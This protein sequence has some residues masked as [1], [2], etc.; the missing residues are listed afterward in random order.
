MRLNRHFSTIDAHA[1]GEPLR[2][3]TGGLPPLPGATIL[4]RRRYMREHLD[5]VR[6][7]LMYEPRGHHG[8]YG[9]VLMPPASP[10]GDLGVLFMH[11]EGYSTMCGH[12]IIA[13]TTAVLETGLL[14]KEGPEPTVRYDTPAGRV[15]ARAVME[16]ERVAAVAF[17]N[18]PSFVWK[19]GLRVPVDG[20]GEVTADIVFGGAFYAFVR[21]E[22]LGLRVRP[23]QVPQ[24]QRA[25][26]AIKAQIEATEDVHH[27]EEPELRDIYGVIFYDRPD[28][29]GADWRNV[30][31]FADQQIDR[32]PC[33]TG[34]SAR[35]AHLHFLGELDP[36]D[37]FIHESIVGSRFVG[38]ILGLTQV[39]PYQAILPE[40]QGS[41]A[42]TGFHQFVVDP[43]DPL[44]R[45]FLL[46]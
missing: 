12:G 23:E 34:T 5:D 30:C 2:I 10:D 19:A 8:M 15:V 31:V 6:Q 35:L 29:P 11:N 14:Q 42:I 9:A 18:V 20:M 40:V 17:E 38:R 37:S 4:E 44:A 16:G 33:G 39:G 1:G 45:G 41:A 24:L 21:A 43:G 13:L 7:I 27:P 25:M 36:G 3:I 46:R 22:E 26:A 28:R 32:S